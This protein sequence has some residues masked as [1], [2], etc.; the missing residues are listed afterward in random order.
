[1]IVDVNDNEI[2]LML[3]VD[4]YTGFHGLYRC[5]NDY[6]P[7]SRR[8]SNRFSQPLFQGSLAEFVYLLV[9]ILSPFIEHVVK[10]LCQVL[11][12]EILHQNTDC[13]LQLRQPCTE[14]EFPNFLQLHPT[15]LSI[16]HLW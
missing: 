5:R 13:R 14:Y 2:D 4:M 10:F 11:A 16:T 8:Q 3:I 12:M 1:M 6:R 9:S 15:R 7:S